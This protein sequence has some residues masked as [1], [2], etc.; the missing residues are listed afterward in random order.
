MATQGG[1]DTPVLPDEVAGVP[2]GTSD[3]SSAG[4]DVEAIPPREDKSELDVQEREAEQDVEQPREPA[5]QQLQAG[6]EAAAVVLEAIKAASNPES[7]GA[8]PGLKEG[9]LGTPEAG[10]P[11]SQWE[12]Y[13][14]GGR[15]ASKDRDAVGEREVRSGFFDGWRGSDGSSGGRSLRDAL[16][17]YDQLLKEHYLAMSF[18]QVQYTGLNPTV[19]RLLAPR[20][21]L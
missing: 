18:A 4:P 1:T 13:L 8:M 5:Q 7:T 19:V 11:G 16:R 3:P 14:G 17:S 20:L 21:D 6:E 10:D 12:G 15:S 2:D 9:G